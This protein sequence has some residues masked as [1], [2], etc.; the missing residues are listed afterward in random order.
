[1]NKHAGIVLAAGASSRMGRPKALL[2]LPGGER[3][4]ARQARLL[5]DAG[6]A[7]AL[8]VLGADADRIAA[9]LPEVEIV[10]NPDWEK[11]RFTSLQA[12]LRACADADGFLILPVD[13]VG[14]RVE[15]LAGLLAAAER[16]SAAALRPYYRSTPGRVLWLRADLARDLVKEPARDLR[17]DERL[18]AIETSIACDD[19]AIL[20]NINTPEEWSAFLALSEMRKISS[21]GSGGM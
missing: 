9:A 21:C 20:H 2:A 19:P 13:T 7:R 14:V 16:T 17:L 4:A 18:A 5:R 6:C 12:G 1:L 11:G 8:V 3:L 10:V 15:T